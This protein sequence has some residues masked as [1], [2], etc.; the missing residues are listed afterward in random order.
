[1]G[2]PLSLLSWRS[3]HQL[4]HRKSLRRCVVHLAR[5][6]WNESS[7]C[8]LK[9]LTPMMASEI[10]AHVPPVTFDQMSSNNVQKQENQSAQTVVQKDTHVEHSLP[11]PSRNIV[12]TQRHH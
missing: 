7:S 8:R 11:W 6:Q 12:Q 4:F 1:M 3:T 5:M 10:I 9:S 2:L